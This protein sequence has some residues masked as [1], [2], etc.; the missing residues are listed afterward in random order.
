MTAVVLD[1]SLYVAAIS[2]AERSHA[3][4]NALFQDLA[5]GGGF[6]VPALFRLEVTAALARRGEP[7][8]VIDLALAHLSGP[9]F[10]EVPVDAALIEAAGSVARLARLRAYDAVYAA[11]ALSSQVPLATLDVD[12]RQRLTA[13]YPGV[14]LLP[15]RTPGAR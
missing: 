13:A 12:L 9:R 11:V 5:A 14:T 1:A 10:S 4:A 6:L 2:P 15:E 8:Q 7:P 3:Q